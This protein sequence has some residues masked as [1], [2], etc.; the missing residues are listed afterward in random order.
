MR[1]SS[2]RK[3][4]FAFSILTP[5][6]AMAEGPASSPP[7]SDPL[8]KQ[9]LRAGQR[10]GGAQHVE[11]VQ[12]RSGVRQRAAGAG[13]SGHESALGIAESEKLANLYSPR[14]RASLGGRDARVIAPPQS[15]KTAEQAVDALVT[16]ARRACS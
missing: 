16:A 14:G 5:F 8:L 1:M 13:R 12:P 10:P 2:M 15:F 7:V 4:L 9:I 6:T 11:A 3:W